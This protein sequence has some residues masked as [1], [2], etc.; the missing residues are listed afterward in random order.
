MDL[1]ELLR[2][3]L[4]AIRTHALRSFLICEL[5]VNHRYVQHFLGYAFQGRGGTRSG[6]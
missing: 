5:P 6:A 1:A 3:A 4:R 2:E